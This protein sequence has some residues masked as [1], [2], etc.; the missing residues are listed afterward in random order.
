MPGGVDG[1][2]DRLLRIAAAGLL[3][4][5]GS[6]LRGFDLDSQTTLDGRVVDAVTGAPIELA[7]GDSACSNRLGK[8]SHEG[9]P[10]DGPI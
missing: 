2:A 9:R 1:T 5:G 3:L 4:L 7:S 6:F 8:E 10:T